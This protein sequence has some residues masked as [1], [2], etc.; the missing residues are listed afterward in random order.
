M[1]LR[2]LLA[3]LLATA[4]ACA[5]AG[6]GSQTLRGLEDDGPVTV[7]YPTAEADRPVQRGPFTVPL[8]PDAPPAAG[9][10]RLV[11]ISHGSGGNPWTHTDLA[12]VLVDAGFTVAMPTHA[13]DHAQDGSRPGPAS[14]KRRPAE[15]SRAIDAVA[16]EPRLA[17]R[18]ALDKVGVFGQS[19]GG[20]TALS[21]AG[22]RWSAARFAQHCL[23]HLE[24]DFHACVGL[25]TRL[26][27]GWL[28]GPKLALARLVHRVAFAGDSAWQAHDDP[29]IAAAVAGVPG[30]ADFDPASL[31]APRVP[32]GLVTAGRDSWLTPG[33]HGL[34]VAQACPPCERLA[35]LPEAGHSVLLS[36]LPPAHV[37]SP[38]AAAL[39]ADPPGFD[40]AGQLPA[41]HATIAQF[42][43]RHLPPPNA[44]ATRPIP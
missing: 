33:W 16:A 3:C 1:P 30:A 24:Q 9:N 28:D 22:A 15:V 5:Q 25:A 42:F 44:S 6:M 37:L 17:S 10:G 20:H 38:L 29:R 43:Q 35:H 8:A 39:L 4:A 13:G 14:W 7:F 21:L 36:P 19:A 41:L 26:T 18:L 32:L 27:G 2:E 23:A 31:A 40:R 34:A 12:R 11:V